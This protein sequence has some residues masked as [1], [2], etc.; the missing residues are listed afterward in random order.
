MFSL[1]EGGEYAISHKPNGVS[2]N[3][4]GVALPNPRSTN[5]IET[6]VALA[7]TTAT[8]TRTAKKQ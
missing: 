6:K 7:T 2:K 4:I 8:A 1:P 5:F 3:C